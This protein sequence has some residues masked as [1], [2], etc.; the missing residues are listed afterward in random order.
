VV[1]RQVGQGVEGEFPDLAGVVARLQS[2]PGAADVDGR[3][4]VVPRI[5]GGVSTSTPTSSSTSR[6][7]ASSM[8][9]P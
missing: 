6:R 1:E 8:R 9:S 2:A 7:A 3:L 5:P 4:R